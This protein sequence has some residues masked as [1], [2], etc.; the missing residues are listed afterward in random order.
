M[1]RAAGGTYTL[2]AGNPV[3][4]GTVIS[5]T[6]ANTTLSDLATAMTD[7]LSRSGLGGMTAPLLG[8]DGTQ[9]LPAY[10][11]TSEPSSGL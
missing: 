6:W 2:P 11:F 5:S 1:S 3:V 7:S 4:T 8:S 10:S 9:A